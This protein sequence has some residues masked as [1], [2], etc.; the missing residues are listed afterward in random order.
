MQSSATKTVDLSDIDQI[1]NPV[2]R[3]YLEDHRRF[4]IFKGGAGAGKS[5]FI[6]EKIHYNFLTLPGYNVLV[7]RKINIDNHQS[8]F[9]ELCKFIYTNN[10]EPLYDINHSRGAEEITCKIN[11]NRMIFRGLDDV[12]KVKSITFPNGDLVCVWIEEATEITEYDFNQINL[13]LRGI[14]AIN[15]H[16][17]LSLNPIDA[18]HW[19]KHRFFDILLEKE[20]GFVLETTYKDNLFIDDEYKRELEGYKVIDEYYYE[21]Y[22]LNHWGMRTTARVFHNLIIEDFDYTE[23]DLSNRRFGMDFGYNHANALV[24]TGFRDSELYIFDE[25]YAKRQLNAAFI[26]SAEAIPQ[27]YTIFADSAEP[28][29][30]AEWRNA[31]FVNCYPV[32]KQG[33]NKGDFLRHGIDYLKSLPK[34]HIHKTR[35]PNTA[36]EFQHLKYRELKGGIILDEVAEINDD[37]V[38]AVR[39]AT[40][41]LVKESVQEHFF[42]KARAN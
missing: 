26:E 22:V 21:V 13:R 3:T 35:C 17:I 29:K 30:I 39:Y 31:G 40:T 33:K 32:N 7:L 8:T 16:I 10:L 41:D 6:S 15:K 23:D 4:Q 2:Y 34:I 5:Y 19:I 25:R 38:A 27:D 42:I 18:D 37:T 12:L 14:G 24:G 36:R 20:R 11:G 9:A 28:D 1:I